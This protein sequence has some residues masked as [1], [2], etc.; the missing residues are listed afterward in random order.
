MP[1]DDGV[2]PCRPLRPFDAVFAVEVSNVQ[3]GF[4]V[5]TA[6]MRGIFNLDVLKVMA[7]LESLEYDRQR[8]SSR[9][10]LIHFL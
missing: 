8:S 4:L 10:I 6:S 5:L 7:G 1:C 3:R 2:L 9:L